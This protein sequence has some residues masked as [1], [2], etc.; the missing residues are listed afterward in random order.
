MFKSGNLGQTDRFDGR[1]VAPVAGYG[2]EVARSEGLEGVEVASDL[3]T[4]HCR[5]A[6]RRL[7]VAGKK[8][9]VG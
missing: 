1:V 7:P 2:N 4:G 6:T 3:A 8:T 9:F 5:P